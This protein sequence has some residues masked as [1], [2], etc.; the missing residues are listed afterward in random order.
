MEKVEKYSVISTKIASSDKEKIVDIAN[1]LGM[2]L[3]QLMQSLIL[4]LV[5]Y[6]DKESPISDELNIMVSSFMDVVASIKG[7]YN[8]L[9]PSNQSGE[10]IQKAFVFVQRHNRERPQI[11][12][13][14][15]D[16]KGE[17]TKNYNIDDMLSE[18]LEILN[19]KILN[20]LKKEKREL[21]YFSL[22]QTLQKI[23]NENGTLKKDEIEEEVKSLFTDIRVSGLAINGDVY[24]KRKKNIGDYTAVSPISKKYIHAD[25]F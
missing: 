23:I 1:R 13:V 14:G 6:F 11:I 8:P 24:Y 9:K 7:S 12:E 17:W 18:F 10:S 16:N 4:A 25:L 20:E 5:R 19:P 3:Y 21:G 2:N 15:K 22:V